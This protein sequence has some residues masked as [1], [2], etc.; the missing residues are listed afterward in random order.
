MRFYTETHEPA[1]MLFLAK[2]PEG[3]EADRRIGLVACDEDARGVMGTNT[4]QREALDRQP[5]TLC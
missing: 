4:R 1:A 2:S 5:A 3:Q